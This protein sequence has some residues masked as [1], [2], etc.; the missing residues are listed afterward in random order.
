MHLCARGIDVVC[1]RS[2]IC[3]LGGSMLHLSMVLIF[4]FGI[5]PT[6]WNFSLTFVIVGSSTS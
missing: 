2:C 6:V 5:V 3:V 1:E 4:D